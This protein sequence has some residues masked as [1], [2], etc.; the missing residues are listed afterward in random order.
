MECRK[1]WCG[2]WHAKRATGR[3]TRGSAFGDVATWVDRR[4]GLSELG[5][6]FGRG[7]DAESRGERERLGNQV[8]NFM[9][10]SGHEEE[11]G[12]SVGRKN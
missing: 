8:G 7:G 3:E 12:P 1:A 11:V 5:R 9:G 2:R 6:R 4:N 10:T